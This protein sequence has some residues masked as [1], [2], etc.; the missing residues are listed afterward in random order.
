MWWTGLRFSLFALMAVQEFTEFPLWQR[1]VFGTLVMSRA[2]WRER[3]RRN[4]VGVNPSWGPAALQVAMSVPPRPSRQ[5]L[6]MNRWTWNVICPALGNSDYL[7][8]IESDSLIVWFLDVYIL[9][10]FWWFETYRKII[11]K[12]LISIWIWCLGRQAFGTSTTSSVQVMVYFIG[13]NFKMT[14]FIL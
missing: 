6:C 5:C 11:L 7:W 2:H 13:K 12:I 10:F 9:I 14:H 4:H 1:H 3:D 8:Q